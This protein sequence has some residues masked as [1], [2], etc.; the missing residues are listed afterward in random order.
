MSAN[1]VFVKNISSETSEKEIREFFSFCG[2]ISSLDVK[3]EGATKEASVTF[4]KETAAKTALLLDATRLGTHEVQV[5]SAVAHSEDNEH[6]DDGTHSD[7]IT[8]EDKPRSRIIAEYLA[9]G[10]TISDQV[11]QRAIDID[12]KR[13]FSKKFLSTLQ[14]YDEKFKA[15]DKVKSVDQTYGVSQKASGITNSLLSGFSSYYEKAANTPTGQKLVNFYTVQQKQVMDIHKEAA[16]LAEIKKK[17]AAG[18]PETVTESGKT[19]CKC[20]SDS[21]ACPCAPG[22]CACANCGSKGESK[23][24]V[25]TVPGTDKTTCSCGGKMSDCPCKEGHCACS[26]CPKA[27][28]EKVAGT[29]KTKCSCGGDDGNCACAKGQCACSGCSK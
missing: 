9:H 27:T 15:T 2:K 10:Y 16:R 26:S 20:G 22:S 23:S 5:T 21:G 18:T 1:Q 3:T 19:T 12:N 11:A 17:E 4:E 7:E 29:E 13:G 25:K 14:T 24:D 28:K 6:H 8:Q